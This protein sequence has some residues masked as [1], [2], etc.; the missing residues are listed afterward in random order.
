MDHPVLLG[1]IAQ[2]QASWIRWSRDV[3]VRGRVVWVMGYNLT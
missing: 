2:R 3:E 1:R